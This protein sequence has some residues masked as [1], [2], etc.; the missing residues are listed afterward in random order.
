MRIESDRL[1]IY[2]ISNEEMKKMIADEKDEGLRQ[3]YSGMALR[4][5]IQ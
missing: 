3:A 5:I 2:P 4:V 1:Y